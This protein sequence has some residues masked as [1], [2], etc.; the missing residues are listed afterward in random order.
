MGQA[1]GVW[2]RHPVR[3]EMAPDR[4]APPGPIDIVGDAPVSPSAA[5]NSGS[6]DLPSPQ[7][8]ARVHWKRIEAQ[9]HASRVSPFEWVSPDRPTEEAT[10]FD[11]DALSGTWKETRTHVK[12]AETPFAEGAMRECFKMVRR[13]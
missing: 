11:F 10:R 6:T 13:R 1:T 2:E 12:I 3:G 4:Q 5:L 7:Q 8:R 9:T